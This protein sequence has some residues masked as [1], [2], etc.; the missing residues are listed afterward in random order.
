MPEQKPHRLIRV[1]AGC[2][3]HDRFMFRQFIAFW[4]ADDDGEL[5]IPIRLI[6]ELGA[7]LHEPARP[8]GAKQGQMESAMASLPLEV[9]DIF[10]VA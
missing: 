4:I 9:D 10:F 6:V 8:A 7:I 3:P 1:A 2:R 5:T